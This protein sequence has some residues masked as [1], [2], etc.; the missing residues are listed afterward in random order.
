MLVW[1]LLDKALVV[2][3]IILKYSL[4]WLEQ[5]IEITTYISLAQP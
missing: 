3:D 4:T 5:T 2:V 1:S